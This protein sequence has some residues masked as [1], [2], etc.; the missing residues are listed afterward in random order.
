[1]LEGLR[2]RSTETKYGRIPLWLYE[3]GASLQAIAAYGWLHGRYGHYEKAIPG[4]KTLASELNVGRTTV[5]GYM[6][7]LKDA[8]ALVVRPRYDGERQTTNEYVIAFNEPFVVSQD[9]TG[10][11]AMP[12]HGSVGRTPGVG[13]PDPRGSVGRTPEED[14]FEKD[15]VKNT[16][17][18][19]LPGMG[20]LAPAAEQPKSPTVGGDE[21]PEWLAFWAA[22]PNKVSKKKARAAYA[23]ARRVA[24]FATLMDG[25]E[26]YLA[27]DDRARRGYVKDPVVWLNGEC[28]DD[29]PVRPR[30]AAAQKPTVRAAD[31]WMTR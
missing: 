18:P 14:V 4:Y 29:E 6:K 8:G 30:G 25:L 22:Y 27:F 5:I 3:S 31:E 28:W 26:R 19:A 17:P 13:T 11:V 10:G 15:V 20:G 12:T 24:T 21:D 23:K 2:G 9:G 1:M 7:E 16:S